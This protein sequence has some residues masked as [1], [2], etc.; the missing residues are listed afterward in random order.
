MPAD[1]PATCPKCRIDLV[2]SKAMVSTWCAG[3][4]DFIGDLDN[5]IRTVSPGGPGKL[6]DCRKC[7]KCGYSIT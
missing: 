5:M 3:L 7:P 2:P 4:P 6:I 1:S